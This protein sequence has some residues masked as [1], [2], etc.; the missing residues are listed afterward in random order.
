MV[1]FATGLEGLAQLSGS[2]QIRDVDAN[3]LDFVIELLS[4]ATERILAAGL[5]ADYVERESDL[6]A[7]R[8]RLL[9]DRQLL[10]RFGLNDRVI[11]RYDEHEHDIPDNQLLALALGHASRIGVLPR[12]RRRARALATSLEDLCDPSALANALDPQAF[13][14]SRHNEHYRP[15]HTLSWMILDEQGPDETLS[16]GRAAIRSFLVDMNTLF[17]RF[18]ERLLRIACE[19]VGI[20]VTAQRSDSIFWRPDLRTRYARIRPDLLLHRAARP[21]SRLPV[22]AKYKRYDRGNVDVD[23]LTQAFLYAY[24]Y[25]D[26]AASGPPRA[27]LIHPTETPGNPFRMPLQVRSVAE[28]TIDA[29]LSILAVHIPTLLDAAQAAST[30][31]QHVFSGL[32]ATLLSP[33]TESISA[34]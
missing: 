4:S 5:R 16:T 32:A 17:E 3:L 8:G 24:A 33:A 21:T 18:L 23:D 6:P 1:E 14:Y 25:R 12:V 2:P 9:P 27:V 31:R 15:A 7:V 11:C 19:P 34:T 22:D 30:D 28:R 13:T 29:E 26:P 10:E 20:D